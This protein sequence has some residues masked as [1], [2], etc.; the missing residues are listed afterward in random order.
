MEYTYS[1]KNEKLYVTIPNEESV[2]RASEKVY[3]YLK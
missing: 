1:I 3:E 2:K